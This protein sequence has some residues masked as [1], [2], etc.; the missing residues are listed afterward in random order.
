VKYLI[1]LSLSLSV[2]LTVVLTI[3]LNVALASAA[4]ANSNEAAI[5]ERIKPVGEVCIEGQP[6]AGASTEAAVPQV[7]TAARSGEDLYNTKCM[8]CH[9][10]GAAGAPMKG[11]KG[12][13]A[14]RIEKGLDQ[15]VANAI[16]GIN[17]MPPKGTCMD[18]SEEE[19]RA[20]VEYMVN[21]SK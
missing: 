1:K 21:A 3:V 15:L 14:P 2:A 12:H 8:A 6:C 4:Q 5:K 19:I 9:G 11:N 18:C 20:T 10:T 17:A 13:W 7:A 16:S